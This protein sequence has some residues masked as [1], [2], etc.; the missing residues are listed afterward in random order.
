[1][2]AG[3]GSSPRPRQA[4][5]AVRY[6]E[7][8]PGQAEPA[9][10]AEVDGQPGQNLL[11]LA[12]E[13]GIDIEHACGGVCAC[14]TCHVY[15]VEGGE[16]LTGASDEELD[17]VDL[18]PDPRPSSRLSCQ[19]TLTGEGPVTVRIPA[20]NRNAVKEHTGD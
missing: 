3:D 1:V 10:L 18:A 17:R 15:I 6:E 20:W 12:L 4:G 8:R 9:T 13:H 19:A 11:D 14:S 5:V 16:A 7:E 2:T